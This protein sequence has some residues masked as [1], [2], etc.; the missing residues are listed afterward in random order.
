MVAIEVAPLT[1]I[2]PKDVSVRADTD[3]GQIFRFPVI[4]IANAPVALIADKMIKIIFFINIFFK[5]DFQITY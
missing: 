3:P 2:P 1:Q 4:G 5:I